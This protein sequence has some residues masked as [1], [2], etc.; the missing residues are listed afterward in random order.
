MRRTRGCR[1][2]KESPVAQLEQEQ[3]QEEEGPQEEEQPSLSSAIDDAYLAEGYINAEGNRDQ[4]ALANA[5][6]PHVAKAQVESPQERTPKAVTKGQLVVTVFPSLPGRED[7]PSQPDPDLAE[8]VHKQITQKVWDLAKPDRAGIVQQLV[9]QR[10]PGFILCRTKVGTDGVDAV[11]VT[12]NLACLREDFAGPLSETMRRAN[13][14][15]A[16]NMAMAGGRL[17]EHAKTFD[18]LYRQANKKALNAG[19]VETQLM[20]ESAEDNGESENGEE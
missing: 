8:E 6:Y 13:R 7:W 19:L 18:R 10:M 11:Y 2:R 15:M 9:G 5:I 3:P 20:L 4:K 17:P 1:S 16:L 12:D 14:R